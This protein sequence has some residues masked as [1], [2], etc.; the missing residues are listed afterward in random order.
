MF[1]AFTYIAPLVTEVSG[2][3]TG[4][5]PWLLLIF[6]IGLFA[7]NLVGGKAADRSLDGT[8]LT[9]LIALA[10]VLAAFTFVAGYRTPTIIA[11]ALMG[12]AGFAAV[13]PLQTRVMK[14]G[15]DAPTMASAI[16]IAAFNVGNALG[17]WLGSLTIAAGLGYTSPLWVGATLAAV[18]IG[19]LAVAI[20]T[21]PR[22]SA[23][24]SDN[25]PAPVA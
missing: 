20:A 15:G 3:A 21:K 25:V 18:S 4:T 23:A 17:A 11:V 22:S 19:L 14:Y 8:M 2:F 16:N 7:G 13:P 24:A 10:V 1:G 6:G 12:G 9:A 5:V